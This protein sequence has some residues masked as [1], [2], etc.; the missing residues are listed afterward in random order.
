MS[1]RRLD[2][3]LTRVTVS[4]RVTHFS[5]AGSTLEAVSVA[6]TDEA[7]T[8]LTKL[9]TLL[10]GQEDVVGRDVGEE[11]HNGVRSPFRETLVSLVLNAAVHHVEV[12]LCPAFVVVVV[13]GVIVVVA[14][15]VVGVVVVAVVVVG[16]VVV[17]VVVVGVVVVA[18]V[19]VGVIVV[20]VVVVGVVVVVVDVFVAVVTGVGVYF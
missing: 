11:S 14:V 15:V 4:V 13:V 1:P 7:A 20:A 3:P 10:E 16:V 19:V 9:E 5:G 8:R 6:S 17:A 2:T 12:T 18:V